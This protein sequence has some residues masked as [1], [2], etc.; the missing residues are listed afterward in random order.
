MCCLDLPE[1]IKMQIR[2]YLMYCLWRGPHPEDHRPAM[3]KW[4][5]VCRPK[6]RGGLGVKDISIQNNALMLKNLHKFFN[7]HNIP[8]VNMIWETYYSSGQLPGQ[9]FIGSFWLKA[10]LKLID[11]YKGMARCILGDGKLAFLWTDLWHSTCLHQTFPHLFPFTRNPAI[12]V[13]TT[14]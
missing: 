2:K 13:N 9:Q 6:N 12:S 10:N 11:Q 3:V 14:L 8:W 1:T 7:R 4:S 5:V